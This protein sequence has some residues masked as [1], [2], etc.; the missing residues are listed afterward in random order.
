MNRRGTKRPRFSVGGQPVYENEDSSNHSA[1]GIT[2]Y[3]DNSLSQTP[4]VSMNN[5]DQQNFPQNQFV[6][7]RSKPIQQSSIKSSNDD[8][9]N[10][11]TC[12]NYL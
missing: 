2:D 6:P 12:L 5:F 7:D 11:N 9:T 4:E 10:L 8:N 3:D 1:L